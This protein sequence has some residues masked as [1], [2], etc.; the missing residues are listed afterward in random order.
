MARSFITVPSVTDNYNLDFQLQ[1][2]ILLL[3]FIQSNGFATLSLRHYI[4]S[5]GLDS[6]QIC[7]LLSL[8]L[9][10]LS[11]SSMAHYSR[12]FAQAKD[13]EDATFLEVLIS[14]ALRYLLLRLHD[15]YHFNCVLTVLAEVYRKEGRKRIGLPS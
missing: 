11:S 13:H 8:K 1:R 4:A 7:S 5:L 6:V 2:K 9:T 14:M 10:T 3:Q 12:K 15:P